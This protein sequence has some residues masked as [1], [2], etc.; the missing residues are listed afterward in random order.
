MIILKVCFYLSTHKTEIC[1]R[2]ADFHC[3][4][5]THRSEFSMCTKRKIV[6]TYAVRIVIYFAAEYIATP[7]TDEEM[8]QLSSSH[9]CGTLVNRVVLSVA[10]LFV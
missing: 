10:A 6:R 9:K 5:G 8:L 4:H 2:T 7:D 3:V 1:L